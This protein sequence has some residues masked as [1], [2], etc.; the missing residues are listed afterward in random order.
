MR[1][2]SK[3]KQYTHAC[4]G[5]RDL[6]VACRRLKRNVGTVL[7]FSLFG[8]PHSYHK[9]NC[10]NGVSS[11][12]RLTKCSQN[13]LGANFGPRRKSMTA[14]NRAR[15]YHPIHVVLVYACYAYVLLGITFLTCMLYSSGS[16]TQSP[17]SHIT[18]G[19][20]AESLDVQ[21]LRKSSVATIVTIAESTTRAQQRVQRCVRI[22]GAGTDCD[23][24]TQQL[25]GSV[26]D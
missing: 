18:D 21:G 10:C 7:Q 14:S 23:D 24:L 25:Q 8:G 2:G 11:K 5:E 12:C 4:N 22:G 19:G 1:Q 9:H 17:E 16:E 15:S 20:F 3:V 26:C 6:P 13:R